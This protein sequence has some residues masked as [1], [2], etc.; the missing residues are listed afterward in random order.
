MDTLLSVL[1][2]DMVSGQME[3]SRWNA[4][5]DINPRV[6]RIS[7][8]LSLA[9]LYPP[10]HNTRRLALLLTVIF[11]VLGVLSL[12]GGVLG[13]PDSGWGIRFQY[14]HCFAFQTLGRLS[15][16]EKISVVIVAGE[17]WLYSKP[18]LS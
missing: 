16:Y 9:R 2:C 7:V 10:Q 8:W 4:K 11:A 5:A 6:T 12:T 13:C 17:S 18:T 15:L 3:R 14:G 1:L